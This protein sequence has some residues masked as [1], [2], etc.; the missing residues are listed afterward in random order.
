[1]KLVGYEWMKLSGQLRI[2]F[3]TVLL[4]MGN[5]F[6]TYAGQK[7][8]PAYFFV[9]QQKDSYIAFC[10]GD[11]DADIMGFYRQE[12]DDQ[13]SYII[14]YKQFI[15]QM[16]DRAAKMNESAFY[17]DKNSYLSRNL[18]KTCQ[19]FSVFADTVIIT[20]NC[21]GLEAF[22]Q[23]DCGI[24]FLI[25]FQG[26]LTWYVLFY[27][28]SRNITL[29]FKGCRRG[30]YPLASAK[31]ITLL[32]AGVFYVLLQEGST[33]LCFGRMYGYGDLSRP[34]QS[35]SLFRNCHYVLTVGQAVAV[36]VLVRIGIAMII[37]TLMFAAGMRIKSEVGAILSVCTVL[38]GEYILNKILF[39][40]GLM[41]VLKILNPFYYWSMK[42]SL[43]YYLNLNFFGY[44]VEKDFVAIIG[45]LFL[46][47]LF[48]LSGVVAFHRTC[49]IKCDGYQE[50]LMQWF[51]GKLGVVSRRVSLLYYEFYKL[52]FQ[53]KKIFAVLLLL[54][55]A[56]YSTAGVYAPQYYASSGEAAYHAYLANLSGPV[57][58]E[59]LDYLEK[60]EARFQQLREKI[61]SLGAGATGADA[62]NRQ[63][64]Q[65]EIE[66]M[67][68]GFHQVQMQVEALSG[69][70]GRLTDK[71][72]MDEVSYLKLWQDTRHEVFLWFAGSVFLLF[73][74]CGIYTVDESSEMMRLFR[75]TRRGR[76][77][78]E[79][80][81]DVAVLLCTILVYL[82][83]DVPLFIAYVHVDN[84]S[85][86]GQ[87]LCDLV[88]LNC[89]G[90]VTLFIFEGI[91]FFLKGLSFLLVAL[92][93]RRLAKILKQE[94]PALLL[95]SGLFGMLALIFDNFGWS[96]H[97]LLLRI[98]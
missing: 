37:A 26:L 36:T 44:A 8:T 78:L 16:E 61:I 97:M 83:V 55:W 5:L 7:N 88:K 68:D 19:D 18:R 90:N 25:I 33:I 79:Q 51:R 27:E 24:F 96:L 15:A 92:V 95:G 46:M 29:L 53:Q 63:M 81:K 17:G 77:S 64:L 74:V 2:W 38:G 86:A 87:R 72:L 52:F 12:L 21:F 1:M 85:T 84:F 54:T 31:L 42:C 39:P 57:T 76:K 23:Y 41:K 20:D 3:L 62:I 45:E 89:A 49:Q 60:E 58:E 75:S 43:G 28:R 9:F 65:S 11:E 73:L 98:L 94:V 10:Q 22:A 59:T 56:I 6:M 14:S 70:P 47:A 4:L 67:E 32:M 34:V 50:R 69:K 93:S 40:A 13:E 82:S 80:N 35:S 48:T 71:Y 30:H 91:V 66:L